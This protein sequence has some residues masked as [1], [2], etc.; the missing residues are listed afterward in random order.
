MSKPVKNMMT[1]HIAAMLEGVDSACVVDLSGL[2][3][4][5]TNTM[6]GALRARDINMHVVKNSLARRAL[7]NSPLLPLAKSLEGPCAVVY[8]APAVT[9]IAKELDRWAKDHDVI[10]LKNGMIEGDPELIAV[11][12]LA[13]MQGK[14]ELLGEI[15][16]L[17]R[18]PAAGIASAISAPAGRIAGCLKSRIDQQEAA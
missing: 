4:V 10:K 6:R 14:T 15:A 3:A 7:A 5:T 11:A 2:D 9:D 12:E 13:R 17:L 18:S 16:M 1:E 8:G